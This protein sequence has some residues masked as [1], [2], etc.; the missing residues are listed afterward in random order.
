MLWDA[1]REAL[2][3][4]DDRLAEPAAYSLWVDYFENPPTVEEAWR[5]MLHEPTDRRLERLLHASGPVPWQLKAPL[6][7]RLSRAPR[8][9][10]FIR[11]ALDAAETDVFGQSDPKAVE[12]WRRRLTPPAS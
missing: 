9:H 12:A 1:Y 11:L 8:W 3:S 6:F 5:E 4:P 2:D 7:E 10:P